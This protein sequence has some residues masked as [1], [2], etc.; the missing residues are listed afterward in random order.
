[1]ATLY[2]C[3][4]ATQG[5]TPQYFQAGD[6]LIKPSYVVME[7]DNDEVKICATSGHPFGV[8]GCPAYHDMNT[9]YTVG[10]RVRVWLLGS[11][12]EIMLLHDANTGESITK[13]MNLIASTGTAG[14]VRI[15]ID[16]VTKTTTYNLTEHTEGGDTSRF[17][18][19]YALETVTVTS[20]TTEFMRAKLAIS[21]A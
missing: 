6:S 3:L 8:A 21:G 9:V 12:V 4:I 18:V 16:Y 5:A 15:Q 7:D 2:K 17:V 19:G 10:V 11:G 13:G 20:G 1:M 14:H